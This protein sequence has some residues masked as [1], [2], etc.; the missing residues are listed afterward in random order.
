MAFHIESTGTHSKRGQ[1][2]FA[3][4]SFQPHTEQGGRGRTL[5]LY[6]MQEG[7]DMVREEVVLRTQGYLVE[8]QLP[9]ILWDYQ[10]VSRMLIHA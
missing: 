10:Y 4:I 7:T 9:P 1:D 5:L 2:A 3:R 8:S 6:P